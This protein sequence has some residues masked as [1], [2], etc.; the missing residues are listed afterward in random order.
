MLKTSLNSIHV[1]DKTGFHPLPVARCQLYQVCS[2]YV[3][4]QHVKLATGSTLVYWMGWGC[5]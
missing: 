4:T 5:C 3:S 2:A 1:V